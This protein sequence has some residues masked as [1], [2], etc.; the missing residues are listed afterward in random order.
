V[1]K[2]ITRAHFIELGKKAELKEQEVKEV[3]EKAQVAISNWR[4]YA[5]EYGVSKNSN[6]IITKSL[7]EV[8]L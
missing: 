1:G 4:T 7:A 8:S 5:E 3:I 2:D 6:S